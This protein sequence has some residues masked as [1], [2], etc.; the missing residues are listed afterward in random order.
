MK[1]DSEL[2]ITEAPMA[3]KKGSPAM[4]FVVDALKQNP[5][6]EYKHIKEAATRKGLAVYPIMYGRAKA[7]LG[8]VEVAPRG[9]GKR[10]RETR[11][12]NARERNSAERADRAE[13]IERESPRRAPARSREVS[14]ADPLEAMIANV[15]EVQE[16][17][18]RY[19]E[20]L[21]KIGKILDEVLA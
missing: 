1:T 10:A 20:A 8:L 3:D 6:T 13:R 12:R 18:N 21:D 15:R 11:E 17:R 16:E 7:L 2:D 5:G 19:R 4:D 14:A 9:S